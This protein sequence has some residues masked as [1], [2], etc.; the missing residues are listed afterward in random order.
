MTTENDVG[1]LTTSASNPD[2][3]SAIQENVE[4]ALMDTEEVVKP[5]AKNVE[6]FLENP[7]LFMPSPDFLSTFID[8]RFLHD[9]ITSHIYH[10]NHS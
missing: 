9:M 7:H 4:S 1:A 3:A 5:V 6:E 8:V 2:M 10:L